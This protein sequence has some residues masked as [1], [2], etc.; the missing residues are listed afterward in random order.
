MGL[1]VIAVEN[2]HNREIAGPAL[3]GYHGNISS[4]LADAVRTALAG[5]AVVP[6]PGPFDPDAYFTW[7]TSL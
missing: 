5:P 3:V 6:D 1:P 7:L 4:S 2:A